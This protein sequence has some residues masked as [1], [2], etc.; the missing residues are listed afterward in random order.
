[1]HVNVTDAHKIV[2]GELKG[3][4]YV[5]DMDVDVRIILKCVLQIWGSDWIQLA[6]DTSS[7]GII[8]Q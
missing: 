8:T 3:R 2:V 6:Q 7:G 1:M 4:C 5:R